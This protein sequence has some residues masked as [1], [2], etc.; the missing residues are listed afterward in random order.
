MRFS[1]LGLGRLPSAGRAATGAGARAKLALLGVSTAA[2]M[3]AFVGSS[4][5]AFGAACTSATPLG[6]ACSAGGTTFTPGDDTTLPDAPGATEIDDGVANGMSPIAQFAT[7]DQS[8]TTIAS[9]V[10]A[11]L[12]AIGVSGAVYLGRQDGSSGP[13]V[14]TPPTGT[15]IATV[16]GDGGNSGTWTFT[17]GTSGDSLSFI[18]IHAGG[19]QG[20]ILYALNTPGSDSGVWDTSENI[21]GG[22]QQGGL[23]NFDAFGGAGAIIIGGGGGTSPEPASIGLLGSGLAALGLVIGMRRLAKR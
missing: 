22:G 7:A 1:G 2:L 20:D 10:E 12:T 4:H 8:N 9:E 15:S 23:S 21:N 3:A 5:D 11:Y 16:S 6:T 17:P 13:G 18:A 19:G 14:G